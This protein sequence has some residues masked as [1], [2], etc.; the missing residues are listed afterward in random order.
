MQFLNIF[1]HS[2]PNLACRLPHIYRAHGGASQAFYPSPTGFFGGFI[3]IF[4]KKLVYMQTD[5]SSSDKISYDKIYPPRFKSLTHMN[6]RNFLDLFQNL[7]DTVIAVVGD[8]L[9][10]K[11]ARADGFF[12]RGGGG[13]TALF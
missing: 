1:E 12:L 9:I 5:H 13:F 11:D 7:T 10:T 6:A 2:E 8:V 3:S 4:R